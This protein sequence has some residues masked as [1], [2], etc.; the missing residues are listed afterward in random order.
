MSTCRHACE[1]RWIVQC[2]TISSH[3]PVNPIGKGIGIRA[4]KTIKINT[5]T[6]YRPEYSV[7]KS[8][9]HPHSGRSDTILLLCFHGLLPSTPHPYA[10]D[11]PWNIPILEIHMGFCR[12]YKKINIRPLTKSLR[13]SFHRLGLPNLAIW[14][15]NNWTAGCAEF[16]V[17]RIL[18]DYDGK[19]RTFHVYS[20]VLLSISLYV[21]H[22]SGPPGRHMR[23][24]G[25][26]LMVPA[27]GEWEALFFIFYFFAGC[28]NSG[29]RI[30][31]KDG[32]YPWGKIASLRHC[33]LAAAHGKK[34]F[35]QAHV[36]T[37]RW[38]W[39]SNG[40]DFFLKKKKLF[41][42]L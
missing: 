24:S 13:E 23:I 35:G 16:A 19:Q 12:E 26:R 33:L 5:Q 34:Y 28:S 30:Q 3:V 38:R 36:R 21:R 4:T 25:R 41:H 7:S 11:H 2:C 27:D 17:R 9:H 29:F 20:R 8:K 31:G 14:G 18:C 39:C 15:L 1:A 10:A 40:N 37:C 22:V 42:S 32:G 6:S